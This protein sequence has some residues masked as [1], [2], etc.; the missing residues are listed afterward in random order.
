MNQTPSSPM[1]PSSLSTAETS[2]EP[3]YEPSYG[4]NVGP[5]DEPSDE[6]GVAPTSARAPFAR[7]RF[8]TLGALGG[9]STVLANA[10]GAFAATKKKKTVTKVPVRPASAPTAT[11]VASAAPTVA[12][13]ASAASATNAGATAAGSAGNFNEAQELAINFSFVNTAGGGR[14]H[15][16]YVVVWIEDAN[17]ALI[18]NVS[19]NYQVGRGDRWLNHLQRWTNAYNRNEAAL[20]ANRV[21]EVTGPT[22]IPGAYSFAWDGR[23]EAKNLVPHGTYYVCIE[24][25]VEKG[26]YQ[27]VREAIQLTGAP[28]T[29]SPSD[30]GD[31][32]RAKFELRARK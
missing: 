31:L 15:N 17:E 11:K 20:G 3:S 28:V 6:L 7:R 25:A 4:P 22:R 19:L 2:Y 26:S 9:L 32:Q 16:P 13:T 30:N 1:Q 5:S 14:F 27:L 12:P 29:K 23:D 18:R 24:A 8:L 10:G 21:Q